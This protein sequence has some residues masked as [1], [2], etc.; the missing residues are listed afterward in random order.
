MQAKNMMYVAFV[1]AEAAIFGLGNV[2][3]KFAYAGITP[4]WC[5]ALRFG[6]AFLVFLLF[7]GRKSVPQLRKA[8]LR[9]WLPTSLCMAASYVAC[10]LAV[11]W[12]SATNAAFF[13][14]LPMLFA[15]AFSLVLLRRVYQ[16]RTAGL[17]LAVL[18]GLYLL[19][20]GGGSLGLGVGEAAGLLC[21]ACIAGSMVLSERCSGKL[22]AMATSTAQT[23]VTFLVAF[24][25][26][27]ISEPMPTFAS[28]DAISWGCIVFL[29]VVGTCVAFFLQNAALAKIPSATVSVVL[30]AEPVVTAVI[31]LFALGEVLTLASGMGC[32]IIV[33]CTVASSM[34]EGRPQKAPA[35]ASLAAPALPAVAVAASSPA[36]AISPMPAVTRWV[37]APA[38]SGLGQRLSKV[39][40]TASYRVHAKDQRAV[41]T[42]MHNRQTQSAPRRAVGWVLYSFVPIGYYERRDAA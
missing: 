33:A 5:S 8:G 26:A 36:V 22:D 3:M 38:S 41:P 16:A 24:V 29:A 39:A 35:S 20:C 42:L 40:A 9:V 6:L 15:P 30:C 11:A 34:L 25:S 37:P 31:S 4:L 13:I 17:Q 27:L 18:A 1:A 28:V 19:S 14:S 2:L 10:A 23:G 7:F 32:V 21:S 12:T